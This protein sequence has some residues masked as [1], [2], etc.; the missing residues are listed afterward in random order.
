[1]QFWDDFVDP[2]KV[3]FNGE[4]RVITV[5]PQ[6]SEIKVKQDLYSAS[7]RWLQR[8]QNASYLPCFETSGGESVGNGLYTGDIY[9]LVNGW[10]VKVSTQVSIVGTIYNKSNSSVSPYIVESG[11]GVIATVSSLA[12]AYNTTGVTVPS[13][14]ETAQAVWNA[15]PAG[16]P[17]STAGGKLYQIDQNSTNIKTT[18]DNIFA[19]TV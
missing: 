6:F 17:A 14:A 7:K 12:Y 3:T 11:G 2:L 4:T 15:N 18:T 1:M 16:M 13:A 9:F 10:R 5:S 8:R 19:V